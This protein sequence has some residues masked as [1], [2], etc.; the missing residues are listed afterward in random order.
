M[1]GLGTLHTIAFIVIGVV[2]GAALVW[3]RPAGTV[4]LGVI[5]GLVGSFAGGILLHHSKYGSLVTAIVGALILGFV[6]R[7]LAGSMAKGSRS[8]P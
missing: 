6:A 8:R 1:F 5:L 3:G 2:L 4:I 7:F